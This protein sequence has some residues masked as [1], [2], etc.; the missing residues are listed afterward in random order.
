M[1]CIYG[2]R[3]EVNSK[4]YIG[5][6][7]DG[8]AE[9]RKRAH[10]NGYGNDPTYKAIKKYGVENFSFHI[11][12]DSI[13]PELLGDYEME[14]IKTYN[15]KAPHGY[16]LTDGGE[17][18]PNYGK[19]TSSKTC[20]KLSKALKGRQ[21]S[22]EHRKKISEANTGKIAPNRKPEYDEAKAFF[23]SLDTSIS[24][25]E[26]RKCLYTKYPHISQT[27]IC[28]WV[29]RWQQET[30][31]KI[32]EQNQRSP[33]WNHQEQIIKLYTVD[34]LST[35]AIGKIFNVSKEPINKILKHNNIKLRSANGH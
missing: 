29:R 3:N 26:R 22:G 27:R 33:I 6:C 13:I 31:Q 35:R 18:N 1:G 23:L 34:F 20:K 19:K 11:L 5:K 32:S 30:G 12:L 25:R 15:S 2:I 28:K 8:I 17:A 21:F 16:N 14:F 7:A 24:I 9:K 10:Y 4:W